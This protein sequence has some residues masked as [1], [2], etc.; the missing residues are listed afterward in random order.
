MQLSLFDNSPKLGETKIRRT[1]TFQTPHFVVGPELEDAQVHLAPRLHLRMEAD[2]TDM[3]AYPVVRTPADVANV[4][5][6]QMSLLPQEHLVVALLDTKNRVIGLNTVYIGSVNCATIRV[7][8]ILRPAILCNA[9]SFILIHNH[10][11]G[12]PTPSPEDVAVTRVVVE[13]GRLLDVECLDHM[14]IGR[15]KFTSL[16]ERSLGF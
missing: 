7:L 4:L 16:R 10:P 8:E 5:M 15:N 3:A 2:E 1:N 11:S 9:T 13:A 6:L 12:D 14:I